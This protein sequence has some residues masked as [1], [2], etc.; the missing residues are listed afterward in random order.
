[1]FGLTALGIVHTTI[2]LIA[3]AAWLV[4]L[5]RDKQ[6]SIDN[7]VGRTYWVA[8]VLTCLTSLGIFQHGGFGK[9]HAL[10]IITLLVLGVAALARGS[11]LFGRA[12]IYVETIAYSL[13]FFFHLIPGIT[14]TATR[15]PPGAPLVSSPEAPQL[16]LASAVLFLLFLVGAVLQALRLRAAN[17]SVMPA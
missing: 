13:T 1:M 15:L 8:T 3:V 11:T 4:A 2:S 7:S 14:E 10:A 6:I 16:Q 9:P 12:S 5:I 17:G